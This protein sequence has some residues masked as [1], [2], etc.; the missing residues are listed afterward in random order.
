MA[1]GVSTTFLPSDPNEL[2]D[3]LKLPPWAK[4]AGNKSDLINDEIA[5]IVDKLVDYICITKQRH[6]PILINVIY[7]TQRKV[8]INTHIIVDKC[9]EKCFFFVLNN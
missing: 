3:K 8:I 1:S 9:L 5:A 6:K 2:C 4:Q 7:Y